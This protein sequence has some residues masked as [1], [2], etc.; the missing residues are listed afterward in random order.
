MVRRFKSSRNIIANPNCTT[1]QLVIAFASESIA[2]IKKVHVA[3]Y[4]AASEQATQELEDQHKQIVNGEEP[5]VS[6]SISTCI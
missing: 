2:H 5:T 3:T 1:S 4:Q 6:K